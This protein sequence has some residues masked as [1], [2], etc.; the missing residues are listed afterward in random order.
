MYNLVNDGSIKLQK[1]VFCGTIFVI[2]PLSVKFHNSN[3]C[4]GKYGK[5]KNI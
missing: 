3:K 5:F 2:N 1:C 4:G